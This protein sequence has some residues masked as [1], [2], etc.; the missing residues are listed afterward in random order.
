MKSIF[1][2]QDSSI[3]KNNGCLLAALLP[4]MAITWMMNEQG[5]DHI[6]SEISDSILNTTRFYLDSWIRKQTGSADIC[7][8]TLWT[9]FNGS[10]GDRR[11]DELL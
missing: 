3:F 11:A 6:R 9:G 10:G 8:T 1:L 7:L 5:A 4:L 2:L